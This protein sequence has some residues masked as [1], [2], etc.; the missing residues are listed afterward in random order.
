MSRTSSE[1][2]SGRTYT[3]APLT[4]ER[5]EVVTAF[6]RAFQFFRDL[7]K[8]IGGGNERPATAPEFLHEAARIMEDRGKQYDQEGGERSMGKTVAAF[9]AV[10]G[11]AGS[12]RE[13]SEAEGWLLMQILKNVRLFQKPGFH[14]D[15]AIDGVAYQA[16]LAE[17]K[18]KEDDHD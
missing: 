3:N 17:A 14:E 12:D 5:N 1:D 11:R 7:G 6:D 15:S 2:I 9:N 10:T 13:L 18:R 8:A 4:A 16:L